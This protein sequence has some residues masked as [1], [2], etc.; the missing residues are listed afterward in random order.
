MKLNRQQFKNYRKYCWTLAS[1]E[2]LSFFHRDGESGTGI[3]PPVYEISYEN[4]R[5]P[6]CRC[7]EYRP[8]TRA[9]IGGY[10]THE[11]AE[12]LFWSD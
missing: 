12:G 3:Y 11:P 5:G 2:D 9:G 7:L 6:G 1:P 4:C 8:F 10:F